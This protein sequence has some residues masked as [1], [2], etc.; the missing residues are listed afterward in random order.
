MEEKKAKGKLLPP[1][2]MRKIKSLIA[3]FIGFLIWQGMRLLCP[4]ME[5]HPVFVYI[6]GLL[7]IRDTSDKTKSFGV[8][9]IKLT[10]VAIAVGMPML[11]LRNF[12]HINLESQWLI[13]A[14]DM[15]IILFGTLMTLQLGEKAGCG[16]L[17]G[18]TAVVYIILL[19]LQGEDNRYIYALMR[20]FQTFIGVF[21]AWLVNVVIFPYHGKNTEVE[22]QKQV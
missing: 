11:A 8:Q 13:I 19:V 9:R 3:I 12:C 7:E 18:L 2:G 20:I 21:V 10:L 6:Y 22:E 4:E 17:T 16:N 15:V 1:I 5:V 14:I